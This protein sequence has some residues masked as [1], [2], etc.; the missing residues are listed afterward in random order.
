[1]LLDAGLPRYVFA[2]VALSLAVAVIAAY[3]VALEARKCTLEIRT[4]SNSKEAGVVLKDL[5]DPFVVERRHPGFPLV[6]RI[7]TLTYDLSCERGPLKEY[8]VGP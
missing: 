1:M 7:M 5:K 8:P 3:A 2:G 6:V 4:E